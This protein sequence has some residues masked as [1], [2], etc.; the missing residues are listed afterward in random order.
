MTLGDLRTRGFVLLPRLFSPAETAVLGEVAESGF[1][2][3]TEQARAGRSQVTT[4]P[5][6]HRLETVDGATVHWEPDARPPVVRSLSPVTHA[7]R[8]RLRVPPAPGLPV[9]VLLRGSR[10]EGHRHRDDLP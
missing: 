8:G 3:V 2:Q 9:L 10:R 5:D 6:G 4:W 1:A 7:G